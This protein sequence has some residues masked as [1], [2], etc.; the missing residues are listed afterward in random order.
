MKIK[1]R[2]IHALGGFTKE[3]YE[4]MRMAAQMPVPICRVE[5][6]IKELKASVAVN[7]CGPRPSMDYIKRRLAEKIAN[8][9]VEEGLVLIQV[10]ERDSEYTYDHILYTGRML[11]AGEFGERKE[12]IL[13]YADEDTA[14]YANQEVLRPLA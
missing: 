10:T 2:I 12:Q 8:R 5:R 11:I 9:A 14:Y 4:P 6:Q 3:E 1:E 13:E 7:K